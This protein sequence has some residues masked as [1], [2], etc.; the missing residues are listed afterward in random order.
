ML[1]LNPKLPARRKHRPRQ[2]LA[3]PHCRPWTTHW[4]LCSSAGLQEMEA[5]QEV[6]PTSVRWQPSEALADWEQV[7][8]PIPSPRRQSTRSSLRWCIWCYCGLSWGTLYSGLNPK[9]TER[10][11]WMRSPPLGAFGGGGES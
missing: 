3:T 7:Q 9:S 6:C 5:T 10:G 11:S 1:N 8:T 2:I 4:Q